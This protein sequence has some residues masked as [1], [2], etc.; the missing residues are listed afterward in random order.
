MQDFAV[1]GRDAH[2]LVGQPQL[3][4]RGAVGAPHFRKVDEA[5]L[6]DVEEGG[7]RG[8]AEEQAERDVAEQL[9]CLPGTISRL[10]V[11]SCRTASIGQDSVRQTPC[12]IFSKP[13]SD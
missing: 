13:A 10:K 5:R 3:R 11:S 7:E 4:R 1:G 8:V 12:M 6:E 9:H 2:L